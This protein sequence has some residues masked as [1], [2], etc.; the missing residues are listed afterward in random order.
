MSSLVL[1]GLGI[2]FILMGAGLHALTLR[3]GKPTPAMPNKTQLRE[4]AALVAETKKMRI[5]AGAVAG[6]GVVLILLT[7]I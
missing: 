4:Q 3:K 2:G 7:F 6:F 5:A 1:I